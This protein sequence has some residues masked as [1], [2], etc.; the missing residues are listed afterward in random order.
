MGRKEGV[1]ILSYIPRL[2]DQTSKQGNEYRNTRRLLFGLNKHNHL[3]TPV[4]IALPCANFV[5]QNHERRKAALK[6]ATSKKLLISPEKEAITL[7][8]QGFSCCQCLFVVKFQAKRVRIFQAQRRKEKKCQPQQPAQRI[9][10]S[11]QT[12]NAH[13]HG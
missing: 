4:T 12:R 13:H 5:S 11:R 10:K 3:I 9:S 7:A 8:E 6:G 2:P 1:W